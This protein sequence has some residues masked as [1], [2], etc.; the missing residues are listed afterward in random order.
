MTARRR[1]VKMEEG[2]AS[3]RRG[4]V[5]RLLITLLVLA[6]ILYVAAFFVVRTDG[7]RYV[8]E[9]R[10]SDA[11]DWPVGVDRVWLNPDLS[12]VVAGIESEGFERHEGPGIALDEVRLAWSVTRLL[13]PRRSALCRAQVRGATVSLQ[14]DAAGVWRP[15][16]F[17]PDSV[18]LREWFGIRTGEAPPVGGARYVGGALEISITDGRLFWWNAANELVASLQGLTIE[19]GRAD[20]LGEAFRYTR[21]SA[22]D[23]FGPGREERHVT[24]KLLWVDG[25][26]IDLDAG[27]A[28]YNRYR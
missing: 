26:E 19:R 24:R 20:I 13:H 9:E 28:D 10:L 11:W 18:V 2:P 14:Q 7:F 25:H 17:F 4:A 1:Q 22:E 15:S 27:R 12:V 23:V 8:V 21:V 16:V 3:D 6:V 5:R